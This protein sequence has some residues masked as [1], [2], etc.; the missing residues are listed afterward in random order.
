MNEKAD[1]D[2][3]QKPKQKASPSLEEKD[4]RGK[5]IHEMSKAFYDEKHAYANAQNAL[6]NGDVDA[7]FKLYEEA[8]KEK[9]K[10]L[11]ASFTVAGIVLKNDGEKKESTLSPIDAVLSMERV[12]LAAIELAKT[13]AKSAE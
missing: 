1:K 8:V 5:F 9:I 7:L 13:F 11:D 12:A 10:Y 3:S 2:D 4:L 6:D